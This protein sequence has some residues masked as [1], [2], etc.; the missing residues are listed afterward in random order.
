MTLTFPYEIPVVSLGFSG[1]FVVSYLLQK[2][3]YDKLMAS[4]QP[5]TV[6]N[7]VSP[8]MWLVIAAIWNLIALLVAIMLYFQE[9]DSTNDTH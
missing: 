3:G 1:W 8:T 5:G 4:L 9:V 2:D 7:I 6:L